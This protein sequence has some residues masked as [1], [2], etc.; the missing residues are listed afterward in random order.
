MDEP[1]V[2]NAGDLKTGLQAEFE[3]E[4]TASDVAA[5]AELSRDSNP[6]HVDEVYAAQTNY[7]GRIV[8]GAFQV[9][10]ASAMAGMYLP[11]R[12]VVV[13]SFLCRFFAPLH[14]PSRVVV[15]GEITAWTPQSA[16]GTLRVRVI[17][18][19]SL[20]LTSEIHVGFTLH[21]TRSSRPQVRESAPL[22]AGNKPIVLITGGSGGLGPNL[23]SV[24]SETY[25]VIGLARSLPATSD[26]TAGLN[27]EW[28][29][30]D[31]MSADWEQI[32]AHALSGRRLHGI[33]HAAWP[34][35]PQGSLLDLETDAVRAQVEFGT[36]TTIRIARFLRSRAAGAARL[37]VLGTIAATLKPVLNISA[38]SLGKAALEHTVRLLA[39]ELARSNI[40]I[41]LV[42]P[43][44]VP[45]GMNDSKTSRIVLNETAKVP[46][47]KLCS[48]EDVSRAVEFFL[49]PGAA[50]V[51][52]Q[53]LPLTGGQL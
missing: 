9:A 6:L 25:H 13:G 1:R 4:I 7:R 2:F 46:L 29:A 51:T 35:S 40:T 19:P 20:T 30:A 49:S 32:A 45:V 24:L 47:G 38:Y 41:N 18:L 33:V 22:P 44:F 39:P 21:E 17:E 53:M 15:R 23:A 50:F 26:P 43:S 42:A 8:H 10:L 31:L 27:V 16:G 5:F 52:G 11:G 37:V 36:V 34:A 12:Q 48:P 28:V 3:R 14:Y